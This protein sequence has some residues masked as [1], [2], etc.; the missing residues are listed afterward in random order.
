MRIKKNTIYI[1]TSKQ[2]N[3]FLLF[4]ISSLNFAD[5]LGQV[6]TIYVV[7]IL[8]VFYRLRGSVTTKFN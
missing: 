8:I 7:T 2:M 1:I 6:Y 4:Y 5:V 3:L